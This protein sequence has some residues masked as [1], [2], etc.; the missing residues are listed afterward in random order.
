MRYQYNSKTK[1]YTKYA[2]KSVQ[3]PESNKFKYMKQL[4][5]QRIRNCL[6]YRDPVLVPEGLFLILARFR[7]LTNSFIT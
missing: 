7:L 3:N 6:N 5:E 4:H 2:K 1:T